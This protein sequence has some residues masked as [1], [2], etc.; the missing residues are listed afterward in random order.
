MFPE[1][2][3][4]IPNIGLY[5]KTPEAFEALKAVL[6]KGGY[7]LKDGSKD[8][9]HPVPHYWSAHL[10]KDVLVLS[11]MCG[12]CKGYIKV[13]GI[14]QH[15]HQCELC[16][17]VTFRKF[18]DGTII[19]FDFLKER[20]RRGSSPSLRMRVKRYDA[21]RKELW[22]Y[23]QPEDGNDFNN[24]SAEKAK[25]VL[26]RNRE[27]Y[28]NLENDGGQWIVIGYDAFSPY[29]ESDAVISMM[30]IRGSEYNHR[31]VKLYDGK[32]YDD[33]AW[34]L[35]VPESYAIYEAWH[36]APLKPS[37]T[38]HE[39]I[40]HAGGLVADCG[41]YYQDGRPAAF[42]I[43]L[44]RMRLFVQHF[45]T[46]NPETWD[47]MI[48]KAPRSGP[49]IIKAVAAFC[50][51]DAIVENKP[52]IGNLLTGFAD[53][54]QGKKLTEEEIAG[55]ADALKD[56]EIRRDFDEIMKPKTL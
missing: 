28:R 56:D 29:I 19:E 31:V 46:L 9:D 42:D 43:H 55:I 26:E 52:N 25:I 35:P 16:G 15:G 17:A 14:R 5:V 11:G 54:A 3:V 49:G 12:S 36:W 44:Q 2:V 48:T 41:Y 33:M 27:N 23:A 10:R 1:N 38:L 22:L 47:E 32:E 53:I 40:I 7:D 24:W 51:P 20:E 18:V 45:T 13:D 8:A 39:S 21:A 4:E 37:P 34:G 6:T 30:E 50:H